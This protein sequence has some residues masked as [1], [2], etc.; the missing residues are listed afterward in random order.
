LDRACDFLHHANLRAQHGAETLHLQVKVSRREGASQSA[1]PK[2]QSADRVFLS[3]LALNPRSAMPVGMLIDALWGATPPATARAKVHAHVSGLRKTLGDGRSAA[4]GWPVVTCQGGYQLSAGIDVDSWEFELNAS[5]ARQACRLGQYAPASASFARAIAMW[6]GPALAD[7]D[8]GAI[9]AAASA[10]NEKRLLAI[11][12]KAEA[13]LHLGW[14][15]EVVAELAPAAAADPLRERLRGALMLALYRRGCRNEALAVYMPT[16]PRG[17][18]AGST[19][20]APPPAALP[21]GIGAFS[22]AATAVR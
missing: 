7:V 2:F 6:R 8:S 17:A 15:D 11:E 21:Q 14:Y 9:Q 18:A 20:T 12:G 19:A 16:Q 5:R 13:D 4:P 3:L 10:L 22:A 1:Q